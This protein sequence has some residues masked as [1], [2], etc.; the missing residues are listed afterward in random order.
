[1]SV[2]ANSELGGPSGFDIGRQSLTGTFQ[3]ANHPVST[4]YWGNTRSFQQCNGKYAAS[5]G[6][7]QRIR[8]NRGY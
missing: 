3:N 8:F 4:Q 1:M 2:Y 7:V 5:N 6:T